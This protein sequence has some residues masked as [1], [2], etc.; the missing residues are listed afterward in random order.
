MDFHDEPEEIS[1]SQ[2]KREMEALQ[3]IGTRIVELSK[4]QLATIPMPDTLD[5]AITEAR[6]L[7][8]HEGKRRQLQ[9]IGKLMRS[10]DIEPIEHALN[11]L[12]ASSKEHATKLHQLE[13]WRDRLIKEGDAV[14]GE[15]LMKY[16]DADRQHIRQ[17]I[18]N[19][20]K[21]LTLNKPPSHSRKLFKY[22]RELDDAQQIQP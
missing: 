21:D 5:V 18:R 2:I 4:E 10:V 14:V 13:R 12:D 16:P 1:R 19:A 17:L 8:S 7:K 9:Y 3:K 11:L 6:R 15:L 20:K 22:L